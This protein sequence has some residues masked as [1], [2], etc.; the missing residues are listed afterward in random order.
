MQENS[1]ICYNL[2]G[3]LQWTFKN[4]SVLKNIGGITVDN[5]GNVYVTGNISNF[6]IGNP[7]NIVVVLSPDE[8]KH[9]TVLTA[10]DGLANP[11]SL[12]YC[13][14]RN[15]LLVANYCTGAMVYTLI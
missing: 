8:Q 12:D 5:A 7:S 10:S 4:D 11:F 15:Q 6:P 9:K 1:V 14:S 13:R 3:T 2:H